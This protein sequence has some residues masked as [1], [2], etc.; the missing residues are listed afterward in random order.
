MEDVLEVVTV[1]E[2]ILTLVLLVKWESGMVEEEVGRISTHHLTSPAA[3]WRLSVVIME[4]VEI[5]VESVV[6]GTK[7]QEEVL[8]KD[9]LEEEECHWLQKVTFYMGKVFVKNERPLPGD[10]TDLGRRM[11]TLRAGVAGA[12]RPPWRAS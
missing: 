2:V 7:E 1:S 12:L 9:G 4:L 5:L 6:N 11:G 8:E 10:N 3:Y